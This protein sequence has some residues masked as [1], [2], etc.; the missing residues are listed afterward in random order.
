VILG[1]V[2]GEMVS[3]IR[4]GSL[5]A[6]KILLVR[7]VSPEGEGEGEPFLALDAVDAGAGD[8]VL[9]NQEGRSAEAILHASGI[10]VRSV[11]VAVVDEIVAEGRT[12]FHKGERP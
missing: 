12:L 2:I 7:P 9:V 6:R 8:R 3:T 5:R 4:H 10:P 1:D 11:I